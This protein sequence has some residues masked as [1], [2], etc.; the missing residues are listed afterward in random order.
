M[1]S[2]DNTVKRRILISAPSSHTL[3]CAVNKKEGTLLLRGTAGGSSMGFTSDEESLR[4]TWRGERWERILPPPCVR[5]EGG[6]KGG[7]GREGKE[8]EGGRSKDKLLVDDHL[9][10]QTSRNQGTYL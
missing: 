8:R 6:R 9:P 5:E 3:S 7:G 4:E 2:V 1:L 10:F